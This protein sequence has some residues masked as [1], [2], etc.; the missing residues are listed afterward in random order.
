MARIGSEIPGDFWIV[1]R[2]PIVVCE[3]LKGIGSF[4]YIE[5]FETTIW[6]R[7]AGHFP[8]TGLES[9]GLQVMSF[10]KS[11]QKITGIVAIDRMSEDSREQFH[12]CHPVFC[13]II[14]HTK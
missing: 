6:P 9:V 3:Y 12:V 7:N 1:L 10:L 4:A 14:E 8:L 13:D 2:L 11:I 5:T